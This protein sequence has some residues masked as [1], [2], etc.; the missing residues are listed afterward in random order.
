MPATHA[1]VGQLKSVEL[2]VV[3]QFDVAA[4]GYA[5]G[6][7]VGQVNVARRSGGAGSPGCARGIDGLGV[8]KSG[9]VGIGFGQQRVVDDNAALRQTG[10]NQ[11]VD[12]EL[13]GADVDVVAGDG[14]AA[15]NIVT[16]RQVG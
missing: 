13:F 8:G 3:A 16:I 11:T 7:R 9:F 1:H 4:V 15:G 6:G 12:I 5:V 2:C 10:L 14:R